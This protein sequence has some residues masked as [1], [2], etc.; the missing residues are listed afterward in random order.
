MLAV[1]GSNTGQGFS[2]SAAM[3]AGVAALAK[4]NCTLTL[5]PL[6]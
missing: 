6:Y 4:G 2:L 1:G 3:V 5:D